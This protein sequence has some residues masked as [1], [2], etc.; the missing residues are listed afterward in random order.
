M[1]RDV[2][3]FSIRRADCVCDRV[4][5]QRLIKDGREQS[6]HGSLMALTLVHKPLDAGRVRVRD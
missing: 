5:P 6:Q 1:R 3:R 4:R 2:R